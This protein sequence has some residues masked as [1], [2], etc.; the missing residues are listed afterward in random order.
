MR[1]I[2]SLIS[3]VAL[4]A[5]FWWGCCSLHGTNMAVASPTHGEAHWP[6]THAHSGHAHALH[7]EAE[8]YAG[9]PA[10][11][12]ACPKPCGSRHC[13]CQ[14]APCAALRV[15]EA[16]APRSNLSLPL[17]PALAARQF[18]V[19]GRGYGRVIANEGHE[20]E[21]AIR[22]HLLHQVFLI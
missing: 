3:I 4:L 7:H 20:L 5:H 15:S 11:A 6:C 8:E 17:L 12:P 16:Q 22:L 19:Q 14:G 18:A 10:P 1:S 2:V 13:N 21:A 9:V